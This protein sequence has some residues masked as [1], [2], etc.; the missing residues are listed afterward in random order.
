MGPFWA[1]S[2]RVTSRTSA[3]V[4]IAYISSV[5]NLGGFLGPT[6]MGALKGATAG[7]TVGLATL[8]AGM[9]LA[10]LLA[11]AARGEHLPERPTAT[12]PQHA[13]A[14]PAA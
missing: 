1:L 5:G 10:A 12:L 8:A 2:T 11:L 6:W 7:F 13:A 14:D 4:G 3:A 9:L